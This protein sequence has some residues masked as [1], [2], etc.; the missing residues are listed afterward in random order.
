MLGSRIEKELVR[1]VD[2]V[3][4]ARH[5]EVHG[6]EEGEDEEEVKGVL[7]GAV[8]GGGW[9][10]ELCCEEDVEV[11]QEGVEED[12]RGAETLETGREKNLEVG[13]EVKPRLLASILAPRRVRPRS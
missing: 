7:L 5:D 10:V 3:G 2:V 11:I 1:V 4:G 6:T 9:E 13:A 8:Q 12:E